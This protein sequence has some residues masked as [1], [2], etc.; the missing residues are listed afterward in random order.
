MRKIILAI[1]LMVG[2]L[3]GCLVL[4]SVW[5]G[6]GLAVIGNDLGHNRAMMMLVTMLATAATLLSS[7]AGVFVG[8]KRIGL[9]GNARIAA[10]LLY[11]GAV[12]ALGAVLGVTS[13][14]AFDK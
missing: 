14:L 8:L 5:T 7:I 1:V 10:T 6:I 2:S 12:C 4:Y 13:L 9:S 11:S 3:V